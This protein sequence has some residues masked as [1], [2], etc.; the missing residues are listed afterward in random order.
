MI[1]RNK[2]SF[3][4][5]EAVM[6]MIII[7]ITITPF[8]ILVATVMAQQNGFSQAQATAVAL[9]EGEMERVTSE[10]FSLCVSEAA[11]AFSAPFAAYTKQIVVEYVN[12]GALDT[13]VA[14]PTDYKRI[15]VRV[16]NAMAGTNTLVTILANDW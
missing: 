11:A 5:I 3:T 4:I 6:S 10:R 14:G 15:Q 8:A 12:A 1:L 2:K 16:S 9:A 7:A 13:S